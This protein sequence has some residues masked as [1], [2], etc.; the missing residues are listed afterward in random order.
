MKKYKRQHYQ[1]MN[2]KRKCV[3]P[4]KTSNKEVRPTIYSLVLKNEDKPG[5]AI[6]QLK[7]D[8]QLCF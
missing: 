3:L 7:V 2:S 4:K 6:E 1:A 5:T 8:V